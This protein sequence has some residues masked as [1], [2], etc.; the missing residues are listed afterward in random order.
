MEGGRTALEALK[1]ASSILILD[2]IIPCVHVRSDRRSVLRR[3]A[4][5]RVDLLLADLLCDAL[6][7]KSIGPA[8][9]HPITNH[10]LTLSHPPSTLFTQQ[11]HHGRL[12]RRL[13]R[14]Q[15]GRRQRAAADM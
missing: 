8:P 12:P 14:A 9:A 6:V 10:A 15:P 5:R 13:V 1:S 11:R 7:G 4:A 3:P 2:R